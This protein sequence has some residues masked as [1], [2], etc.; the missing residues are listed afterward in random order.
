MSITPSKKEISIAAE[1][2]IDK[3]K[4]TVQLLGT[5]LKRKNMSEM[6]NLY[7]HLTKEKCDRQKLAELLVYQRGSVLFSGKEGRLLRRAIL[8]KAREENEETIIQLYKRNMN[9]TKNKPS[10]MIT[11]LVEK[12]WRSGQRWARDFV[13]TFGFPLVFAGVKPTANPETIVDVS[14]RRRLPELVEF[15]QLLKNEMLKVLNLKGRETRCIIT[16]PTGGG[17]T[18]V[19][20]EAFIEWM[21]PRFSQQQYLIWVAQSEELCEQAISCIEALW[22]NQYF[23]EDLR[24]Y[25]YFGGRKLEAD[26]LIGGVVVTSIQQLHHRIQSDDPILVEIIRNTGAMIIDEAHRATTQMYNDLIR[27]A[28]RHNGKE[29]FPICGLTATPGRNDESTRNLVEFFKAQL[30]RPKLE[31]EYDANPVKYFREHG[32]LSYARHKIVNSG[33]VIDLPEEELHAFQNENQFVEHQFLKKLA[34]DTDR[35][36]MILNAL[37]EIPQGSRVLVY[38]CTVEHAEM[39][40]S[41]MSALGRRSAAISAKTPTVIRR[42]VLEEFREGKIE[43]IFNYGVLTTGF[44]SPK[45]NYIVLLRPTTSVVLYEQIIG[46]GLRGPKFG[47]TPDCTVIDFA[48]NILRLGT[49]LAYKR[50]ADEWPDFWS[51]EFEIP[52]GEGRTE[53]AVARITK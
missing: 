1:L 51:A 10:H 4:I 25:R 14:P 15:Q 49:P 19:A 40:A 31:E 37:L 21:Q 27:F 36:T 12:P 46:R 16:L 32:Y 20:V 29:L 24:I 48:D 11:D 53:A 7:S 42:M 2:L 34:F 47:G 5:L 8:H 44:D 50:F 22:S 28:E 45:T 17:K 30:V 23:V 41:V 35:N 6:R 13:Q 38:A 39:L 3:Y 33:T 26:E 18:R 9:G 43:F 52:T